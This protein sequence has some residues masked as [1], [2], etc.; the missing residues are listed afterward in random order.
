M[1]FEMGALLFLENRNSKCVRDLYGYN[2]TF[3]SITFV[4]YLTIIDK[5]V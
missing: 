4:S 1:R 5:T 3:T 2:L